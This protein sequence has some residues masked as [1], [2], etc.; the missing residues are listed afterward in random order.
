[1][2]KN[3]S[4]RRLDLGYFIRPASETGGQQPRVEPVLAY[5]VH[6]ERGLILF[7]TGIGQ[8]DA[9]T[10]AH[11]RP[12]RRDLQDAL[13]AAGV[14]LGDIS[15]VA[16]CH[17]HF[18]H[19]GGN[20]LLG[21]RPI[22]VQDVELATAR[23]GDYTFDELIDFP[24]ASYEQLAGEAEVWPDVW[25]IPTPGHAQGHQSLVLRQADGTIVLAGQ[26]HDFASHF[27]S[28]Q[29]ARQAALHGVEQ[30]LPAYPHWLERLADFDPRRVLFAHDC[31]VWEPAQSTL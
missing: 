19:C 7:D 18:D 30:P 21:G 10:E 8:A 6:H 29:L 25:I 17:L 1:M 31:S 12:R 4:V 14:A 13:S 15:L 16:N 26:A 24:A 20:P 27:A 23:N 2:G 3:M 9:E 11:Y 28:D 22:L 5:L